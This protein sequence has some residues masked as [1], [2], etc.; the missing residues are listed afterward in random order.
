MLG[1]DIV[2]LLSTSGVGTVATNL[3]VGD[4]PD[5]VDQAIAVRETGGAFTVHTFGSGP[6]GAYGAGSAALEQPRVQVVS[7]AT[8]YATARAKMQDAFNVLDGRRQR[9]ING[10]TYHWIRAVQSPFDLGR[11]QNGRQRFACNFDIVKAVSSS[12]ST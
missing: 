5:I 12:T 9:T 7:R 11:D 1:D 4:V 3:F 10:V 6:S 8:A 2:D